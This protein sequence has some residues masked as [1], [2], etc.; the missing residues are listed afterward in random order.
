MTFLLGN[1]CHIRHVDRILNAS[2][3][4]RV[5]CDF[6]FGMLTEYWVPIHLHVYSVT[7]DHTPKLFMNQ[8]LHLLHQH[9]HQQQTT[10]ITTSFISGTILMCI[11]ILAPNTLTC[12]SLMSTD[13]SAWIHFWHKQF[14]PV[15][16][17]LSPVGNGFLHLKIDLI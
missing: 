11:L 7:S 13:F 4:D 10:S 17:T 15:K 6:T 3:F 16:V 14:F 1:Q 5:L 12:C 8:R 2:I 9:H